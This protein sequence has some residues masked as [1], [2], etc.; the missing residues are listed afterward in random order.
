M[1]AANAKL[2]GNVKAIRERLQAAASREH[3]HSNGDAQAEFGYGLV[4]AEKAVG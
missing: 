3:L 2:K 4:D 1:L